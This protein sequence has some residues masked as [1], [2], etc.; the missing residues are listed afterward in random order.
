MMEKKKNRNALTGEESTAQVTQ[1]FFL[2]IPANSENIALNGSDIP[3]ELPLSRVEAVAPC[4][5][6][7][8]RCACIFFQT[9]KYPVGR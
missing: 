1:L 8:H 4:K 3:E 6:R 2:F 9:F 7:G 5:V